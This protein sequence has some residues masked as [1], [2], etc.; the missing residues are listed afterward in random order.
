MLKQWKKRTGSFVNG[1]YGVNMNLNKRF[2]IF[3]LPVF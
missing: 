2:N 1:I 3:C